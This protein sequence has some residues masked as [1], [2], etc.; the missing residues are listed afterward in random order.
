[1][2]VLLSLKIFIRFN[3]YHEKKKYIEKGVE[4]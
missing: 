3:K 2:F 4:N 1:M